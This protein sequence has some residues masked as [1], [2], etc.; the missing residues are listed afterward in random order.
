MKRLAAFLFLLGTTFTL[1]TFAQTSDAQY[2]SDM[3]WRLVGPH[4]AGRLWSVAGVPGDPA[5]YYAGTPAGALWT[6]AGGAELLAGAP[7]LEDRV[8]AIED[9]LRG[10]QQ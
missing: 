1:A 5:T 6:G 9:A 10:G 3:K 8:A 2:F 4:R 7:S